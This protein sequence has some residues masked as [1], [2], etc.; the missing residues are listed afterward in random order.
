MVQEAYCVA[1][2]LTGGVE[3]GTSSFEHFTWNAASAFFF[4]EDLPDSLERTFDETYFLNRIKEA[5][6]E[7]KKL[8]S[9]DHAAVVKYL[10]EL[11]VKAKEHAEQSLKQVQA[12]VARYDARILEVEA[13]ELPTPEHQKLKDYML[14]ELKEG[15]EDR[16]GMVK[17]Y[18]RWLTENDSETPESFME[19][20]TKYAEARLARAQE[21]LKEEREN[22]TKTTRWLQELNRS[23][24]RPPKKRK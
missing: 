6:E 24:P 23:V 15:R 8:Q 21:D 5:E 14:K 16:L 4:H 7:L 3:D 22:A 18:Q 9:M 2:Y 19:R 13:W 12:Q 1:N 17:T 10:E 20:E 11:A